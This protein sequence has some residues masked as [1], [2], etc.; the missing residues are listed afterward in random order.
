M[1]FNKDESDQRKHR[2]D[3]WICSN[4]PIQKGVVYINLITVWENLNNFSNLS[5]FTIFYVKYIYL[6]GIIYLIRFK[7]I[8]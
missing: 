3:V 8:Y 4:L 2:S 7:E 5:Y 6:L 1:K